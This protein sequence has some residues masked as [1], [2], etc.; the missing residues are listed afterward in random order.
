MTFSEFAQ[1]LYPIIGEGRNKPDF[2]FTLIA[3][4]MDEP[5]N[6]DKPDSSEIYSTDMLGRL[7]SGS[8]KISKK[9]ASAIISALNKEKFEGYLST[10]PPDTID[11]ITKALEQN[12]VKIDDEKN[13]IDICTNLFVSILQD[14][15]GGQNNHPSE[16]YQTEIDSVTKEMDS[17][18]MM[19]QKSGNLPIQ[20]ELKPNLS[21]DLIAQY[22]RL[23]M[24]PRDVLDSVAKEILLK[25][26]LSEEN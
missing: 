5:I 18:S 26:L 9:N 12:G 7:F 3:N 4:I 6:K 15:T 25:N 23:G 2:I 20:R 8:K 16:K 10:F 1:M 13:T 22:T 14:C 11:L 19:I 21:L 24:Y 17:T